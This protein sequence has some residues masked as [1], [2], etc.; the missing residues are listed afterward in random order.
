MAKM[1]KVVGNCVFCG[2]E[3]GFMAKVS[4]LEKYDNGALAQDAFPPSEYSA[5]DRE[6]MISSICPTCQASIFVGGEDE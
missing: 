6:F 1:I 4:D 5:D 2:K 3:Y